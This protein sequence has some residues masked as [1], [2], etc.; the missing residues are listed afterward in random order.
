MLEIKAG[1][2]SFTAGAGA[3][4]EGAAAAAVGGVAAA[5]VAVL[6]AVEAVVVVRQLKSDRPRAISPTTKLF[7][8]VSPPILFRFTADFFQC[9]QKKS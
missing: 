6:G 1:T 9:E 3:A 4:V 7:M 8:R 5:G 2:M